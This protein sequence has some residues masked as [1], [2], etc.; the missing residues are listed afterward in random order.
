MNSCNK[1]IT[2]KIHKKIQKKKIYKK[3]KICN[4]FTIEQKLRNILKIII[5]NFFLIFRKKI[6]KKTL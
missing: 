3:P 6:Q 5:T 1:K 4:K 2:K